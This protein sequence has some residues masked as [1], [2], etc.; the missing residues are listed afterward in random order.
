MAKVTMFMLCDTVNNVPG[1]QGV[2]PH[3]VSPQVVL[4]PMFIPGNFSFGV[5]IGVQEVDLKKNTKL[6]FWVIAPSG[7]II[8]ESQITEIPAVGQE[9]T[10]PAEQQ[11]FVMNLDIRNLVIDEEGKHIFKLKVNEQ[12]VE[13][14]II[15][16]YR[17]NRCD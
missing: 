13:E 6:Q 15:P 9:D 16:I 12:V 14:Q 10:I 17:G 5:S 2:V 3:L 4:R 8:Q 7:K 1:V 11:G